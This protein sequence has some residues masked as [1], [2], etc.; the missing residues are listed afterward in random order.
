M[1]WLI[2][3]NAD[4]STQ[5]FA[6]VLVIVSMVFLIGVNAYFWLKEKIKK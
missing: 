2:Y 6:G 5:I 1:T 3:D 4:E